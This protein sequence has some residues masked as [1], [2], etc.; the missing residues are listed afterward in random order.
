ME[1]VVVVG[2]LVALAGIL[3]PLLPSLILQTGQTTGAA[4]C[5]EINNMVQLY[6]SMHKDMYPSGFDSLIGEDGK[7]CDYVPHLLW[8]TDPLTVSTLTDTEGGNL[9]MVIVNDPSL[10]SASLTSMIQK[11]TSSPGEWNPTTFPYGTNRSV[12]PTTTA[13]YGGQAVHVAPATAAKLFGT[14]PNGTYVVFGLGKN[15]TMTGTSFSE[16]PIWSI[17]DENHNPDNTYC[18]YGLVF[19][20]SG[21]GTSG[22]AVFLGAVAFDYYNG[23]MTQETQIWQSQ[24][25][26]K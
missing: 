18:R 3:V 26:R 11:P 2:I 22:G 4:N 8:G 21:T 1:L 10:G 24:W 5:T 12:A 6:A 19:Q 16:P 20:A 13:L 9:S 25:N 23:L 15:S 17:P 7:I 14:D